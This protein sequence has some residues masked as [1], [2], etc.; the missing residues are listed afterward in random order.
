MDE[1]NKKN[2]TYCVDSVSDIFGGEGHRIH[3]HLN[4]AQ[5]SDLIIVHLSP[6][7]EIDRLLLKSLLPGTLGCLHLVLDFHEL[8]VDSIELSLSDFHSLVKL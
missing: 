6:S 1:Y 5:M 8:L 3:V 2:W 4:I 7:E